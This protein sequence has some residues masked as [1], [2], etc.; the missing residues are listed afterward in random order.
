[1]QLAS[2]IQ[3]CKQGGVSEA[4]IETME[5]KGQPIGL[6]AI[7]P[8]TGETVPVYAANFVL[9]S[10]GTGAVM[11]VPAHDQRDWEFAEKY[12]I[13]KKQVIITAD[14]TDC[15]IDQAAYVEKGV[16]ANSGEFD[17]MAS[18]AAFDA[19]ASWLEREGQRRK[20]S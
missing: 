15:S 14:G 13:E 2:F 3:E 8:V 18:A 5:K 16:L 12:G 7:H 20:T 17:G 6:N 11:A 10:Y 9:M 19:I 1:M 4:E